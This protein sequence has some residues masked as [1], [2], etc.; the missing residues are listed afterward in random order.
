M[1]A[2]ENHKREQVKI[3][4]NKFKEVKFNTY[5]IKYKLNISYLSL[6]IKRHILS[7][8]IKDQGLI[9]CCL[10]EIHLKYRHGEVKNKKIL[11]DTLQKQKLKKQLELLY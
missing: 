2:G 4:R 7:D 6:S 3:N 5:L 10:Q 1:N 9:T 8:R 11:K